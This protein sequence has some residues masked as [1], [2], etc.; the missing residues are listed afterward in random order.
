M[1][2]AHEP[3]P[4]PEPGVTV[5]RDDPLSLF[6]AVADGPDPD[7]DRGPAAPAG[8]CLLSG[9]IVARNLGRRL[10]AARAVHTTTIE[11]L[12]ADLV[13]AAEGR[14]ATVLDR[15]VR[16]RAIAA[17]LDSAREDDTPLG[18]FARRVPFGSGDVLDGVAAELDEYQ[19]C[20]D[21]GRDRAALSRVVDAV[22]D[23][24]AFA[25]E[26]T[27]ESV[28]AFAALDARLSMLVAD[29]NDDAPD[30]AFPSRSHL[31]GAARGA[32][33]D[34]WTE[35]TDDPDWV[36]LATVSV[37]D[38]PTLRF[39]LRIAEEAPLVV[40]A[41]AGTADPFARRFAAAA[42]SD[43]PVRR[44]EWTPGTGGF[45]PLVAAAARHEPA[46]APGS[47]RE[48]AV[49]DPRREVEYAVRAARAA[50][51]STLLVAPDAGDYGTALADVALTG[52]RPYR[53]ETRRELR[54]VP[55]FRGAA[56][57]VGLLA[58][59][60]ADAVGARDV[61]D[62]LRLGSP[63]PGDAADPGEW[64]PSAAS[65]RALGRLL[66]RS[67]DGE[68]LDERR[69]A[70]SAADR[71]FGP[72]GDLLAWVDAR[73][74]SPPADGDDLG[75]LLAG[76]ADARAAAVRDDDVRT[77]GGIAVETRRARA[78]AEHPAAEAARVAGAAPAAARTY[79]WLVGVIDEPRSWE[80]ALDAVRRGAGSESYGRPP[81]DADAVEVV[82]AGNA[83]FR[84]VD[85]A[86]VLGL[87]AERFPRTPGRPSFLHPAVRAAVHRRREEFPYLY[88]DGQAAQYE[89]DL[90]AYEAALRAARE[91]VTLLRPYKDDDGRD[92]APS[93]FL[94]ALSV[95]DE[96]R[97]RVDLGDWVGLGAPDGGDWDADAD[98]SDGAEGSTPGGPDLDRV[99][100]ALSDK[101]RLRALARY[102]G[103]PGGVP[104]RETLAAL[105]D[106]GC[107]P[108]DGRRVARRIDRF[109]AYRE[110]V[111]DD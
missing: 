68:P 31:V 45:D 106:R 21:A 61:L 69:A 108:E 81:I 60:A 41:G 34:A 79:D 43:L 86:F 100:P 90:D 97:T 24:D 48:V 75:A 13:G 47:V 54:S 72:A 27:R 32:V 36:A 30:R 102:A 70:L 96:R 20:T 110:A 92:V 11:D 83:Y 3:E 9:G 105:A 99:W 26:T 52:D 85:R 12:A 91:G 4:E 95:P 18:R 89:R 57:V 56:A 10:P 5:R 53:V 87:A 49:P 58:A 101:E 82:D 46:D 44:G 71:P 8:L 74:G 107:D 29:R 15:P 73:R 94:D 62:P 51:G 19:R 88:L 84:R 103:G 7:P 17:V 23:D 50:P 28:S 63:P 40:F 42:G 109:E 33:G 22:A 55:A 39:L 38:D 78:T 1:T 25:A 80:T 76:I 2:A 35:A 104:D 98:G 37:L 6:R 16:E 66:E 77:V 64:P 14:R 67:P 93:P 59:A 65:V 111:E